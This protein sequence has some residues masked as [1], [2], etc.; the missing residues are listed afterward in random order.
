[1]TT[2]TRQAAT[3]RLPRLTFG[4]LLKSEWIKL[5]SLRSTLWSYGLMVLI[6]AG[7]GVLFSATSEIST[8]P[9]MYQVTPALAVQMSVLI[10]FMFSQLVAAVLGALVITGEYSTGMIRT[11]LTAAPKRVSAYIAK[12]VVLAVTTAAVS[13][14]SVAAAYLASAL[15]LMARGFD[16]PLFEGDTP[17]YIG[18]GILF[19]TCVSIFALGL[20][21]LIRSGAGAI[22]GALG[23][24]LVLPLIFQLIP[25]E[26]LNDLQPYLF[27]N[28]GQSLMGTFPS[29]LDTGLNILYLL[30]WPA[31]ALVAGGIAL[32]RRDA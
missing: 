30:L 4:G 15:T 27:G 5:R 13:V 6:A 25:L 28:L 26:W 29:D 8:T 3:V 19:I 20:G 21:A 10:G 2:T 18:G 31:V 32:V 16:A 12:A 23:T 14:V 17:A 9:D 11:T 1:M 22:A 24:L 7:M